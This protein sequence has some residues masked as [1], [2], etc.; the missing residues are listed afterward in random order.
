MFLAKVRLGLQDRGFQR[1]MRNVFF[2]SVALA[3]LM[4]AV[5]VLQTRAASLGREKDDLATVGVAS[6]KHF[7]GK[8]KDDLVTTGVIVERHFPGKEQDDRITSSDH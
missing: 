3:L 5:L 6:E 7:P 1:V 4:V 2:V 8:E